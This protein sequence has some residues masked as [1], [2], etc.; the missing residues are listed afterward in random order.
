MRQIKTNNISFLLLIAVLFLISCNEPAATSEENE[1]DTTQVATAPD[2]TSMP[3][4]DPA[5]DAYN[6]GG[7]AIKKI[8]DTLSIKMYEVSGKPGESFALHTHPDHI[9]YVLQGGT[10]ALYIKETGKVDTINFPTGLGLINGPLSD[11]G[12]NIG[13]TTVKILVADIHRPRNK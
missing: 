7:D 3:A 6:M 12:K 1:K 9:A 10:V 11:S 2:T 5:M 8:K 4:Y 13:K